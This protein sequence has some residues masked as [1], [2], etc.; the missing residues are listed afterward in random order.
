M[1]VKTKRQCG[2]GLGTC[3]KLVFS[4]DRDA[5]YA[6]VEIRR[7]NKKS[8]V[9]MLK[10]IVHVEKNAVSLTWKHEIRKASLYMFFY[11]G[12]RR[13]L[14][15]PHGKFQ[16]W[17]ANVIIDLGIV[18][19]SASSMT[20]AAPSRIMPSLW[21][22]ANTY[23]ILPAYL[24]HCQFNQMSCWGSAPQQALSK[25]GFIYV[26]GFVP[27]IIVRPAREIVELVAS[28]T[29]ISRKVFAVQHYCRQL[30]AALENCSP[31]ELCWQQ[32]GSLVITSENHPA[33]KLHRKLHADDEA[34]TRLHCVCLLTQGAFVG[35]VGSHLLSLRA[36]DTTAEFEQRLQ[37]SAPPIT[38]AAG[39]GDLFIFRAA[40]FVHGRPAIMQGH[41]SPQ[42][43]TY[44]SWWTP[45]TLQGLKHSKENCSCVPPY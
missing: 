21:Q 34:E 26:Q 27:E 4:S 37:R 8:N 45:K 7:L 16:P 6:A 10:S 38:F 14:F 30:I 13:P 12:D 20:A 40:R 2:Q 31:W 9:L 3:W 23:P 41:T 19:E 39:P 25:E 43:Y 5:L 28:K 22:A 44:S 1:V 42:I 11:R 36:S 17:S 29:Y 15:G 32:E 24:Q 33:A 18:R 35:C